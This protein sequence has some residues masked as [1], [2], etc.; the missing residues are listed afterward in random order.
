MI[1]Q[2]TPRAQEPRGKEKGKGE[3][4]EVEKGRRKKREEERL[5]KGS[6]TFPPPHAPFSNL[7]FLQ[8]H[9]HS[10]DD[11]G[12]GEREKSVEKKKGCGVSDF[13]ARE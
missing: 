8:T 10:A 9:F 2:R 6:M 7:P 11:R 12:E 13:V 3:G 4:V 1:R 5:I